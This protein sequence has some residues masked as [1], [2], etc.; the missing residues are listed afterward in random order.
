MSCTLPSR[1][2]VVC[3]CSIANCQ[4]LCVA[5]VRGEWGW[6]SIRMRWTCTRQV[7]HGLQLQPKTSVGEVRGSWAYPGRIRKSLRWEAH[8][9]RLLEDRQ[10][11]HVCHSTLS[12]PASSTRGGPDLLTPLG[13]PSA[14]VHSPWVVRVTFWDIIHGSLKPSSGFCLYLESSETHLYGW[15]G[16]EWP[17]CFLL[18]Q[19]LPLCLAHGCPS[20]L[21]PCSTSAWNTFPGQ[22]LPTLQVKAQPWH[23]W[24]LPC[25]PCLKQRSFLTVSPL[26]FDQ[27]LVYFLHTP[28]WLSAT[29]CVFFG[30]LAYCRS[31]PYT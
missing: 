19:L 10:P 15:G 7:S 24:V 4:L 13:S 6:P 14:P 22:L 20:C 16:P 11:S 21:C 17:A 27:Y 9:S 25:S 3:R 12:S 28:P 8:V 2:L 26:V 30:L 18:A 1:R 23:L 29:S 31:S 5:P